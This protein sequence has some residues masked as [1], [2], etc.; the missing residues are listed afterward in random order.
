M[1]G[2]VNLDASG[3]EQ[4]NQGTGQA[5]QL[6]AGAVSTTAAGTI[7]G[8]TSA[9]AAPTV[10]IGDCTDRRGNFLLNPVTGGGAQAAGTVAKVRFAKPYTDPIGSVQ[11]VG[12][13]ETDGNAPLLLG[14]AL[15][16]GEGFDIVSTV[17]TTAKAY[18]IS[19]V[20][21]P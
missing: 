11:L 10:T 5:V 9:G 17:L 2:S 7:S 20:V 21:F 6:T 19:Y 14:V 16:T 12:N 3:H 15:L 1:P 13:N 8:T 18:R 4:E